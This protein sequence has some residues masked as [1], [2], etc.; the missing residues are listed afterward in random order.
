MEEEFCEATAIRKKSP[1][2]HSKEKGCEIEYDKVSANRSKNATYSM[3]IG[4][5]KTHKIGNI[6][7]CG[8]EYGHHYGDEFIE[9]YLKSP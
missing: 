9:T 2:F 5:C 6:C 8:W 4:Y 1:Y 3:S 7:H